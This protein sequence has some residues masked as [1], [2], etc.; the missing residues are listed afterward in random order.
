MEKEEDRIGQ[1]YAKILKVGVNI[2][3]MDR[4]LRFVSARLSDKTKFYIVTPNPEIMLKAHKSTYLA[5]IITDSDISVPDGVG[6]HFAAKFID[7]TKLEII[8]GKKLFWEI[9][10]TANKKKARITLYGGIEGDAQGAKEE[11]QKNFKN[12]EI[13]ALT[14]PRY[15]INA[16]PINP[17]ERDVHKKCMGKIK[18]FQP[19][20]IFIGLTTPKQECWIR[21]NFFNF[22]TITGAMTIGDTFAYISGRVKNPPVWMEKAGLEWLFRMFTQPRRIPRI[23][24]ATVV[25]PIKVILWKFGVGKK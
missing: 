14:P 12:L 20:M 8:P 15:D 10:R 5:R 1:K 25:F 22:P 6:L 17:E 16:T 18:I 7:G 23:F 3:S 13:Q 19:D 24:N 4:V 21:K 2:T 11:L 9:L